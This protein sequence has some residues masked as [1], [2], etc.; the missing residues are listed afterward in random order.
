M[1]LVLMISSKE[2][3]DNKSS[4]T[5][6]AKVTSIVEFAPP[7]GTYVPSSSPVGLISFII[8]V[9]SIDNG[10]LYVPLLSQTRC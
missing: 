10:Y 9:C 4:H 2:D 5:F 1:L 6:I 8:F 7:F 3:D